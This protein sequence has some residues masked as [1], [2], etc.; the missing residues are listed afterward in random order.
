MYK[1]GFKQEEE[2]EIKLLTFIGSWRKQESLPDHLTCLLRKLSVVQE[3]I[4][5]TLYGKIYWLKVGKGV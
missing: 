5:R 1:L 2:P 3:A 4:V